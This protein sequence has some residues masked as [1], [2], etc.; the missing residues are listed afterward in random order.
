[1]SKANRNKALWSKLGLLLTTMIWGSTFVVVKDATSALP[2]SYIIVW[3]FAAAAVF[4][5]LIFFRR[6]KRIG[7]AE[8]RGGFL[9][10]F[11]SFLGYELQTYGVQYTT[12]GNN[13]VLT[14]VYCVVVPFLYWI[15]RH[16][17]PN[18]FQVVSA[19]LCIFGVGLLS[20]QGGFSMHIGDVLSLLCG[21][22][23]A[24]QIVAVDRYA[25]K[26]D[27]ILTVIVESAFIALLALPF[28]L[29]FEKRPAFP[30]TGT[31]LSLLY[32]AVFGTMLTSVLQ[33]FSQKNVKPAQASLIMSLES[34]F[35]TLCGVIF[36]REPMTP[37]TFFGCA[38]IF[39]AICL[40]EHRPGKAE[41]P[42]APV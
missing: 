33:F 41:A 20:L 31:V 7:R 15:V 40:C 5:S 18:R 14:S 25:E 17:R 34:V 13:A 42:A 26:G 30:G 29:I 36:L 39:G 1:M 27:P 37:R 3:R 22:C 2:P 9:I 16:I 12:A 8:L 6:L 10:A 23:F 32:L 24:A 35:G 4:L 38:L 11:F 28:A 21:L 19:F